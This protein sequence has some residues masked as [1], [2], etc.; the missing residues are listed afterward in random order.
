MATHTISSRISIV[1]MNRFLPKTL[2]LFQ[3]LL[4]SL[5]GGET[6]C[7][8]WSNP[9]IVDA[10][11]TK[12]S[13]DSI[14]RHDGLKRRKRALVKAIV[15]FGI[16]SSLHLSPDNIQRVGDCLGSALQIESSKPVCPNAPAN[17][18]HI[19]LVGIETCSMSFPKISEENLFNASNAAKLVPAYGTI[20]YSVSISFLKTSLCYHQGW[21]HP[22][23]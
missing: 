23:E 2:Q 5:V 21:G 1:Q 22:P 19:N 8:L 11:S 17:P 7:H 18:P 3:I 14:L 12:E 10:Q 16:S 4:D 20:P 13:F 9:Q 6:Q 15:S